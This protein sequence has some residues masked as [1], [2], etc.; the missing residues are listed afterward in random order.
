M[1]LVR[2]SPTLGTERKDKTFSIVISLYSHSSVG[3]V[4]L[5]LKGS[6]VCWC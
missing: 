6:W 5:R 1:L 2:F 4:K 3:Q